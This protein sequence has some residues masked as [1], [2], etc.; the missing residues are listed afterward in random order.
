MRSMDRFILRQRAAGGHLQQPL[1]DRLGRRRP[2]RWRGLR[3]AEVR[4]AVVGDVVL[5]DGVVAGV[6]GEE[7]AA[8]AVDAGRRTV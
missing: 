2:R 6:E 1:L 8:A 5:F 4:P 7:G 3:L